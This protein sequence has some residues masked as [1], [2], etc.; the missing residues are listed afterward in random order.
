M[1]EQSRPLCDSYDVALLDLDGVVYLGT[2]AVPGAAEALAAARARG[3]RLAY[4]T[5]NA[6]RRPSE[7]AELLSGLGVP[8]TAEDVVTSGQAAARLLS[9]RLPPGA[10]VLV[11]G[12]PALAEEI[13]RV[14]LEP[15]TAADPQPAAVVQGY[16]PDT[17]WRHLAE[18]TVAI[19]G[20]AL[21]VATNTDST[22][23]SSRGP[24]PGNGAL[25]AAV[26]LATGT[27]PE[28]VGKPRPGLHR[29]SVERTGAAHPLVVGD[30]LDTDIE[31]AVAAGVDSLLVLTGVTTPALLLA[32]PPPHQPTFV[33]ADLSGMLHAY[34]VVTVDAGTAVC[35]SFR[36]SVDDGRLTLDGAGDNPIDAL[37]AL[38]KSAWSVSADV[39]SR[40]IRI[41]SHEAQAATDSL[42]LPTGAR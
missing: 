34:P 3:M 26:A 10:R 1:S 35:R 11:V 25:V 30:R 14:G 41:A 23:P 33:A 36:A 8:A 12:S 31:G 6:S 42:G 13:S 20:G 21:W 38:C 15:V 17:S 19:R 37:R 39:S 16:F 7:V 4:V 18:A 40:P 32:A 28:A 27:Q 9:E 2:Q 29:E 22:V 5:N 24:L